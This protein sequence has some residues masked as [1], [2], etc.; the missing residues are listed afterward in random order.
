MDNILEEKK[1]FDALNEEYNE[2]V[3]KLKQEWL[4]KNP[5]SSDR[6]YETM[7]RHEMDEVE[8]KRVQWDHYIRPLVE[9]WW[10]ERGYEIIW[11]DESSKKVKIR[12]IYT[13]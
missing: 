4:M 2:Y 6:V 5:V 12:K 10:K 7:D 1:K 11:P 3:Q 9:A 13:V 8:K